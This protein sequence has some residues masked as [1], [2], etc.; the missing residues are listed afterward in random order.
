MG[1]VKNIL[2]HSPL[3]SVVINTIYV[4]ISCQ[5]SARSADLHALDSNKTTHFVLGFVKNIL[6][7]SPLNPIW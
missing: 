7:H 5:G 1:L 6:F 4:D 3:K 2:F